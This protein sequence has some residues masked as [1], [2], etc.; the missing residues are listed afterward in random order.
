MCVCV[1]V[2]FCVGGG[3]VWAWACASASV[4]K[5]TAQFATPLLWT[6]LQTLLNT[7]ALFVASLINACI[8]FPPQKTLQLA[9]SYPFF[10]GHAHLVSPRRESR[11]FKKPHT[12]H[13]PVFLDRS[14][15]LPPFACMSQLAVFY[16]FFRGHAHL[17]SPRREPW[18]FGE[19]HTTHLRNALRA[20]Y[21]LLP[22][23]YTLFRHA[24]T[25]GVPLLRPLW[26]EFPDNK[27]GCA[28][29]GV[30]VSVGVQMWVWVWVWVWLWVW[31]R[32]WVWV[33]V[34][35]WARVWVT[36]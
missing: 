27:G 22:Y 21:A 31:A 5:V 1:R 7:F 29:V 4:C 8:P 2:R 30:G 3:G 32:V 33:W 34:W 6:H 13:I 20:R 17:E 19:P 26:Y 14:L 10:R 9:V 25:T 11:R 28:D 24:N 18:L 23:M 12:T 36:S 15:T 35:V 16:P